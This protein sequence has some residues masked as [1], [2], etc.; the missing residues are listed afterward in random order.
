MAIGHILLA[1]AS[2]KSL[3]CVALIAYC[4]SAAKVLLE[5]LDLYFDFIK[6]KVENIDPHV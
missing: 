3:A 1:R 5:V 6:L 2:F 4:K